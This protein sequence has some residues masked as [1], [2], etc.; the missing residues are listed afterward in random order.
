MHAIAINLV[1]AALRIRHPG[2]RDQRAGVPNPS[3]ID[4]A[5]EQEEVARLA[6]GQQAVMVTSS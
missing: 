1:I 2:G 6:V 5:M 4:G 3:R